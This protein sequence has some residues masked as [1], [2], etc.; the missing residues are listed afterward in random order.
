MWCIRPTLFSFF[1]LFGKIKGERD[2]LRIWGVVLYG[3]VIQLRLED[4]QRGRCLPASYIR[5]RRRRKVFFS[6]CMA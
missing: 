3:S 4:S 6:C 1:S 5:R 2:R